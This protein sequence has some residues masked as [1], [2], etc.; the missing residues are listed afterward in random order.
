MFLKIEFYKEKK[1][2]N[3]W[4]YTN[5]TKDKKETEEDYQKKIKLL[6]R[7][8][9]VYSYGIINFNTYMGAKENTELGN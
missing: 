9:I 2:S 1:Y 6:K 7:N 3:A 5:I 4:E 8:Y